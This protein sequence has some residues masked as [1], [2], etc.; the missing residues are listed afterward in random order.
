MSILIDKNTK[1]IVQGITGTQGSFHT[2]RMIDYGT[3]V[4]AGV[5]PGKGGQEV[6]GVPVYNSMAEAVAEHSADFSVL[7]VPAKFAKDAAIDAL[8]NGLNVVF[9]TEDTP[10]HDVI[11]VMDVARDKGKIVVGPNCPGMISPGQSKIGIMPNHIFLEGNVGVVSR[12]GTL[13]YEVI[14]ELTRKGIGQSTCIGI[15]GDAIIGTNFIDVLKLFE[16]D[17][18]TEKI[19]L[20]GE[21]GGDQE[22]KAAEFIKKNVTKKVVAYIAG[23]TA[24][25]GKRMGHAGAIISGDSGTAESKIKAFEE[26]GVKVAK[27]PSG[28]VELL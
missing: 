17:K 22:E 25:K 10:I 21:I 5:T 19:V 16:K 14:N 28:I 11:K 8:S 2:R 26:A 7:F 13:T 23:I 20:L 15:G 3:Q 1:V 24:P 18:D 6:H 9:I 27:L 4:V 12:S